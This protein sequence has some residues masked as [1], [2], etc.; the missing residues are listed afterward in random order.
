MIILLEIV[1][2]HA[3]PIPLTVTINYISTFNRLNYAKSSHHVM[4]DV[5]DHNFHR[6]S[7]LAVPPRL[8]EELSTGNTFGKLGNHFP[9]R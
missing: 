6:F 8:L 7:D 9:E 3:S 2:E 4:H 1:D 5:K